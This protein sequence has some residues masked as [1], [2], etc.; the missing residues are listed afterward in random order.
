MTTVDPGPLL[1]TLLG[2]NVQ[3]VV[4][5]DPVVEGSLRLVVSAHPTNLD[6]LGR[7]LDALSATARTD[8]PSRPDGAPE[9]G[10]APAP[11]S[12]AGGRGSSAGPTRVGDPLGTVAVTTSVCD[13]LLLFGGAHGS[14]YAETMA[15]AGAQEIAGVRV[16]WAAELPEIGPPARVTG[17]ALGGRLLSLAGRLAHLVE[18]RSD[19][20]DV[21]A[22][23]AGQA[24][25][26]D[27]MRDPDASTAPEDQG[28]PGAG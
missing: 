27:G 23:A 16:Q 11:G 26:D 18:R 7:A 24:G 28:S 8:G 5:G 3:F 25:P 19:P 10:A 12:G 21:E 1:R 15:L 13:V 9:V 4:V 14:L 20:S 6:A 22:P 17:G 2:A